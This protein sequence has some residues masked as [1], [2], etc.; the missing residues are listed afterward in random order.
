[1]TAV[2]LFA[3]D[4][5]EEVTAAAKKLRKVQLQLEDYGGRSRERAIQTR[6]DGW[7]DREGRIHAHQDEFPR[8]H[9]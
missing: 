7:Q 9:H 6:S 2:S 8:Q 5:K 3:A 4:A 1:M